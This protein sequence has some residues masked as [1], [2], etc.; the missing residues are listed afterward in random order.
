AVDQAENATDQC[1]D[2]VEREISKLIFELHAKIEALEGKMKAEGE[3][4]YGLL[5]RHGIHGAPS[6][7]QSTDAL[8]GETP[9]GP[10]LD[11]GPDEPETKAAE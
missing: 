8:T 10:D 3:A 9:S 7:A 11:S 1:E 2:T 5:S 4:L 6:T